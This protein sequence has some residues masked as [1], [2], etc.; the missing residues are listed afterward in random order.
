MKRSVWIG[1]DPREVDGYAVTRASARANLNPLVPIHG[2][3]LQAL[4]QGGLYWRPT[5]SVGCGLYDLI[6]DAPMATE[7]AISRF[8]VP[9][10]AGEGWALFLDADM[11][12]R[13]S[14][15]LLFAQADP[16]KA[17][18]VVKH[19][20]RP[21]EKEK[22]DGQPQTQYPRKNWSSVMLLNC[23]HPSNRVLTVGMVNEMPGRD[24][25]RF[26]WLA[27]DEIGSLDPTWNHLVGYSEPLAD[28]AIVHFTSGIPSMPGHENDPFADEWRAELQ[29]WAA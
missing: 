25:H 17:A 1:W 6:S 11:L 22:M 26:C 14:L 20:H 23:D 2:V 15:D 12:V 13:T 8:L 3:V 18:M 5:M 10:L 7:F 24:L 16:S 21:T 4:N 27:D 19:D 9:H 29:R 28:P